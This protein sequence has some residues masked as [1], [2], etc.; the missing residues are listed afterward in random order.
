MKLTL[1]GQVRDMEIGATIS[2]LLTSLALAEKLVLV[3]L[4]G[5]AMQREISRQQN[6]SMVT[7][8]KSSAWSAVG[9]NRWRRYASYRSGNC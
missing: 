9:E 4:N 3:E 6:S 8:S 7:L 1:N 5:H 2:D